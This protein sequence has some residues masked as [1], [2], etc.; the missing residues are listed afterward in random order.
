M[1]RFLVRIY[2]V[3]PDSVAGDGIP[4]LKRV[5]LGTDGSFTTLPLVEGVQGLQIDYG[6]D[7]DND[8]VADSFTDC[9]ACTKDDWAQ[10]VAARVHLLARNL[11]VT[12]GHTDSKTYNLGSH[13]AVGPYNDAYKRRVYS[14]F[15]RL[16][17]PAGRKETP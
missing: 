10:T 16:I 15:I 4:T 8:G 5:E 3:A 14:E 12:H 11:D 6:L 2:F 1:R 7:T 17:N 9:A 13:G